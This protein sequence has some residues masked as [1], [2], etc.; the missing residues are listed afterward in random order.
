MLPP[1]TMAWPYRRDDDREVFD[2]FMSFPIGLGAGLRISPKG[3][4]VRLGGR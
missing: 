4:R 3:A 2:V 1:A